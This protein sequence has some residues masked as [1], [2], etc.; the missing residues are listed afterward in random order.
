MLGQEQQRQQH[1]QM[2]VDQTEGYAKL[3]VWHGLL[4][5]VALQANLILELCNLYFCHCMPASRI[6]KLIQAE[7]YD[8]KIQKGPSVKKHTFR[9]SVTES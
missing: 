6:E 1:S 9:V 3:V 5:L 4:I 2:T 7:K 8:R